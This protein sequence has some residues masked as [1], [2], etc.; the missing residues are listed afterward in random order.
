M[1]DLI[2]RVNEDNPDPRVACALLLDT[3][4]SMGTPDPSMG[5]PDTEPISQL[6]E[7]FRVFCDE[8]KQ[9]PLAKKRT[10][11]AVITFGG[12]ARVEIPFTEGR[13]LQPQAFTATG[14]TPMGA[15][16]D[17]A[18]NELMTQKRSYKQA[19][20]EYFRPWLF[21]ITDGAPTDGPDF[22]RAV[23]RVRQAEDA[24]GVSIFAIGVGNRADLIQ[25]AKLSATRQPL[26]LKGY[27]FREMFSWLSASMGAVSRSSTFGSS[28]TA[29][30]QAEAMEQNPLPAPDGWAT[31]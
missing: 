14:G 29:V 20:L 8:I 30:A 9:D 18:L 17:L 31:W 1:S 7:G 10:E 4:A 19:G 12:T 28:D 27:S 11:V 3:S 15:A 6:N 5:T 24:K 22:E 13:D 23:E 26:M 25:L 21:L 16:L 2:A